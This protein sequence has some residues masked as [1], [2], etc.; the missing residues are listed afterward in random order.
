MFNVMHTH[1][2]V[3]VKYQRSIN[4]IVWRWTVT[5]YTST[6]LYM[7]YFDDVDIYKLREKRQTQSHFLIDLLLT[8]SIHEGMGKIVNKLFDL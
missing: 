6:H 2:G 3:T 8:R 4:G 7:D 5:D 1:R